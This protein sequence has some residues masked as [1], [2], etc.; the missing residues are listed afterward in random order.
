MISDSN[1]QDDE[2]NN[3]N[4]P[5]RI[6][7]Y[8]R[9]FKSSFRHKSSKENNYRYDFDTGKLLFVR[10]SYSPQKNRLNLKEKR[11][12]L[13]QKNVKFNDLI[14]SDIEANDEI[15]ISPQKL[16]HLQRTPTT[17]SIKTTNQN[18]QSTKKRYRKKKVKFKHKFVN[19]I[20]VESYKKYNINDR[21]YDS[22][23]AKCTC[24]IY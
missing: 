14:I 18:G 1:K 15:T 5:N 13:S 8:N 6:D 22:A 2:E 24:L 17:K 3:L 23:N 9:Y 21:L 16:N 11:R 20:N 4:N 7:I 19:I 10:K 12:F